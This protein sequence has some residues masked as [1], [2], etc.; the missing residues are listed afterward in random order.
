[1]FYVTR[2]PDGSVQSLS[3]E[4]GSGSESLAADHPDVQAFL[5]AASAASSNFGESD[6]EFVRVL[7]DLIDTLILKNV[8]Y[9]TDLP[10]A[11][12]KKLLA[13]KGLRSRLQGALTLLGNDDRLI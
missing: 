5:G 11:A 13:R 6:A 4:A 12:Q 10:V 8:I 1:M 7:E 2:N 9:H 3:K